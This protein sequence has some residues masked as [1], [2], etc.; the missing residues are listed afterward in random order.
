MRKHGGG[1]VG[2]TPSMTSQKVLSPRW[3]LSV[4]C[5][6]MQHLVH[7]CALVKHTARTFKIRHSPS[8][9][10]THRNLRDFA[11]VFT[12]RLDEFTLQLAKEI[13]ST[14]LF[15]CLL[16]HEASLTALMPASCAP[17][18][19]SV[20]SGTADLES[21]PRGN[22]I[23]LSLALHCHWHLYRSS[24]YCS[25][26][27]SG[28]NISIYP[29]RPTPC[30]GQASRSCC[31]NHTRVYSG[32]WSDFFSRKNMNLRQNHSSLCTKCEPE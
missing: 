32:F 1:G 26:A 2:S 15:V 23:C 28:L 17:Y 30:G 27:W 31:V 8:F 7:G 14:Q 29:S 18:K 6:A 19:P 20:L 3:I 10:G 24:S 22:S 5:S 13:I 4:C 16:K 12:H 25:A 9:A 11:V 21:F